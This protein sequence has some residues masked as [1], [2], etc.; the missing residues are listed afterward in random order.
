MWHLGQ[1]SESAARRGHGR[2][3]ACSGHLYIHILGALAEALSGSA[4]SHPEG[5]DR[6]SF[7][8]LSLRGVWIPASPSACPAW[9]ELAGPQGPG[10]GLGLEVGLG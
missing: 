6:P 5:Q 7:I 4:F 8:S 3:P 1:G 9:A 2:A 10:A